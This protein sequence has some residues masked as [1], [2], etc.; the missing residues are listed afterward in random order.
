MSNTKLPYNF[1]QGN[2]NDI[3]MA[4]EKIETSK[5]NAGAPIDCFL[6]NDLEWFV[7]HPG[8]L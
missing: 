6:G 4:D 8:V 7:M 3:P 5:A 2:A 1:L